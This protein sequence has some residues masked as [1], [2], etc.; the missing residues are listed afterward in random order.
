MKQ[1]PY[2]AESIQ[3]A[4]V[5]CRFCQTDLPVAGVAHRP[6]SSARRQPDL[7]GGCARLIGVA[8]VSAI[9]CYLA[10]SPFLV[11]FFGQNAATDFAATG[12]ASDP[13]AA[14]SFWTALIFVGMTGGGWAL[15]RRM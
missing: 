12:R 15:T 11:G 4:A 8:I 7:A 10:V 9:V 13:S 14:A 1:C 5:K 3:D 2:C 6:A